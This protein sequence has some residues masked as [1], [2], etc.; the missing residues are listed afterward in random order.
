MNKAT[1]QT[2]RSFLKVAGAAAV[3]H[4]LI[5]RTTLAAN[6]QRQPSRFAPDIG[7]CTSVKNA[8]LLREAGAGYIEAGVR[9]LLVPDQSDDAFAAKLAEAKSCGLPVAAANGF[10]PGSLKS[11][12]PDAN[13][14]GVLRFA[15]TAFK[16][17]R[18]VG[19]TTIVFGSSGSR[20]IPDGF[21][22]TK[23]ERQ[24][25]A[26]LEKMG[27]LAKAGGVTVAIEPLNKGETNF[28]NTLPQ[29]ATIVAAV[30]HPNIRLTADIFHM[31]RMEEPPQ[32]IRDAARLVQH[33]HIAEKKE[34]TAPG[35]H[36]DVFQPYF[37]ALKD[38]GYKGRV[39][40]ECRWQEMPKQL[41]VA[42]R[43]LREQMSRVK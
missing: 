36:G 13:H 6:Q 10:L 9:G 7:V 29:G 30:N 16:R 8:A 40:I 23:A 26:L 18:Q 37:Q 38:I 2:R 21:E 22:R 31:L 12:G 35:V 33:V 19:I 14:E 24:F 17:A 27:P 15:E 42:I 3:G 41:P 1:K 5:P 11:T 4:V 43:F 20:T 34:R 39:S 32:H 28:I 25:L